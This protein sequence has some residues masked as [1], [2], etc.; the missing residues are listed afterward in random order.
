MHARRAP[1]YRSTLGCSALAA[2][3]RACRGFASESRHAFAAGRHERQDRGGSGQSDITVSCRIGG[4]SGWRISGYFNANARMLHCRSLLSASQCFCC[5]NIRHDDSCRNPLLKR[6]FI[7]LPIRAEADIG[8]TIRAATVRGRKETSCWNSDQVANTAINRCHPIHWRR[9]SAAMNAPSAPHAWMLCWTTFVPTAAAASY[10]DRCGHRETGRATTFWER[11]RPSPRYPCSVP[12]CR[13]SE[14]AHRIR[15]RRGHTAWRCGDCA[16][17]APPKWVSS[18]C[19]SAG[20]AHVSQLASNR[21]RA[22]RWGSRGLHTCPGWY[23]W[24][25]A[26]IQRRWCRRQPHP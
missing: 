5:E 16:V 9:A 3:I 4:Y 20:Y 21:L 7:N 13:P 26:D 15:A 24:H 12:I 17:S 23:C 19:L 18:P 2:T 8:A 6:C 11:I 1:E 25:R 14:L 10:P 22:E